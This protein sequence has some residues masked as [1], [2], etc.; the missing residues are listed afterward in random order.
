MVEKKIPTSAGMETASETVT[1]VKAAQSAATAPTSNGSDNEAFNAAVEKKLLGQASVV[2]S[3]DT[4]L[5][6]SYTDASAGIRSGNES[7][8]Q[9]IESVYQREKQGILGTGEDAVKGFAEGRSGFATQMAGLRSI[10]QTTDKNLNDLTQR[11]E[12][13]ILQGDSQA[14]GQISGLI[15]DRL[16]FKQQ[17][18]QQVFGNLLGMA[19]YGQQ[20]KQSADQLA[21][22]KYQFDQKMKYDETTAMS[23]IALEYGLH[24]QPGET[25]TTLYSRASAE[26]GAD[27]PAALKIKQAQSE[28]N[29]NNADIARIR[30]EIARSNQTTPKLGSADLDAI[31]QASLANPATMGPLLQGLDK[32]QQTYVINKMSSTSGNNT[33]Q[34][35][36]SQGLSKEDAKADIWK[37]TTMSAPDKQAASGAVDALYGPDP[38]PDTRTTFQKAEGS[39]MNFTNWYRGLLG[40][41]PI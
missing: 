32:N 5:E 24:T 3:F 30:N 26:M 21:Q 28:I 35:Y 22:S 10:V 36:K 39:M 13:L 19:N 27:S 9:R 1:R 31:V 40:E 29:R 16:K 14:A 12:E 6:Q 37:S 34:V 7:S 18:E 17:A 15:I 8:K 11:K 38:A 2:S 41:K 25:L 33:A 20:K 23:S 4:Q